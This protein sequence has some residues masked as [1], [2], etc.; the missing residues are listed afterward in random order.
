MATPSSITNRRKLLIGTG[1]LA[2]TGAV[3][4]GSTLLS[5]PD[6]AYMLYLRAV[7]IEAEFNAFGGDEEG[8][9]YRALFEIYIA[10][11]RKLAATPTTSL[12]GVWGKM[13]RLAHDQFWAPD[14]TTL[15]FSLG[16]SV[17]GDLNRMVA[18]TTP[19]WPDE[20]PEQGRRS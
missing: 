14:D 1:T 4:P 10:T 12:M 11:E 8:S 17:L 20:A 7:R 19:G 15:E 6:P 2:L 18:A 16:L 13:Q 5:D 3:W 9:E